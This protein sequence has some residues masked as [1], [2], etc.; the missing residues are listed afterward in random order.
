MANLTEIVK[1][2]LEPL[3]KGLE[4]RVE[5]LEESIK[6]FCGEEDA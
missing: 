1:N 2:T 4:E 6:E 3:M 5:K